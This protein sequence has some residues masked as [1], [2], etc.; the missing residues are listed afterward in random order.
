MAQEIKY[1]RVMVSAKRHTALK[2]EAKAK[3]IHINALVESK[4]KA[5]K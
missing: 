3:G 2:K 4:L 5:S 1:P